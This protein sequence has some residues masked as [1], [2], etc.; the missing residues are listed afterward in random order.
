MLGYT[1]K[2]LVKNI[3]NKF[4]DS[5]SLENHG[6]WHID[7]IKP[8]SAFVRE[9]ITNPKIINAL[10]N[11]QSLWAKDNLRKNFKYETGEA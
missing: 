7:H 1:E 4:T 3:E 5:M 11:L 9:G 2:E 6:K 8:I 10:S